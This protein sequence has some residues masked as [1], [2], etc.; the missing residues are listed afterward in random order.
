M[1]KKDENQSNVNPFWGNIFKSFNSSEELELYHIL[2][3]I[4]LFKDLSKREL[5]K[6]SNILHERT[7]QINE[8]I[9][10]MHQPGAA[11]F[12]I[13]SGKVKIIFESEKEE[14]PIELATLVEGDFL[15]ELALLDNSPRSAS[16]KAM[17]KTDLLAIFR[18][19]LEKLLMTEPVIGAKI[20]RQLAVVIGLRL[21][22]TNEQLSNYN[23][24][25]GRE[26]Q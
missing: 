6:V 11:M 4:P 22:A 20:V 5:Q 15:G 7:Y 23:L 3:D 25:A 10:Q 12:I 9:F 26:H 18:A 16:A 14:E 13:K 24:E 8:Y 17:Q 21:K 1:A 19:D 2:K